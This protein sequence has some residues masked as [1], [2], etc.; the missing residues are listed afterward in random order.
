VNNGVI[1]PYSAA[2]QAPFSTLSLVLS[3]V[4]SECICGA[5]ESGLEF[6]GL[7]WWCRS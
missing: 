6:A 3:M 7:H 4:F 5:L 2:W 1:I